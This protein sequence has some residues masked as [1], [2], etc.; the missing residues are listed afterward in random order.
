MVIQITEGRGFL[1]DGV[2]L[3]Q[4]NHIFAGGYGRVLSPGSTLNVYDFTGGQSTVNTD[5]N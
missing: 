3:W 1:N 2:Y 5:L 4:W